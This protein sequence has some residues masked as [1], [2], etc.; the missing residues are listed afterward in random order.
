MTDNV[1]LLLSQ[2]PPRIP[3]THGSECPPIPPLGPALLP[4]DVLYKISG[5]LDMADLFRLARASRDRWSMLPFRRAAAEAH[6]M[7]AATIFGPRLSRHVNGL[8]AA[9]E[10]GGDPYR[11]RDY[12]ARLPRC[13][14]R[15]VARLPCRRAAVTIH[16]CTSRR[17][18]TASMSSGPFWRTAPTSTCGSPNHGD[19]LIFEALQSSRTALVVEML[20]AARSIA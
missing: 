14:P 9:I 19:L 12:P 3:T 8:H 7:Q 16:P 2:I 13:R 10:R 17:Y 20:Q 15:P 1:N 5:F 11:D 6:W 4:L 18:G